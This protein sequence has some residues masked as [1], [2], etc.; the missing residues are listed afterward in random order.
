MH[1]NYVAYCI[2]QVMC[3]YTIYAGTAETWKQLK[4]S[5]CGQGAYV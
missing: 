3:D 4:Q 5:N 2:L 1:Y